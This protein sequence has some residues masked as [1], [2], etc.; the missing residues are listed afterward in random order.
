MY[1]PNARN[2]IMQWM[3]RIG[4]QDTQHLFG[5]M[6]RHEVIEYFPA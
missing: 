5:I 4:D 6:P 1:W 3:S 2:E